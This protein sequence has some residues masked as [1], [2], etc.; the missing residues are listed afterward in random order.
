VSATDPSGPGR[1][2]ADEPPPRAT[3]TPSPAGGSFLSPLPAA[4]ARRFSPLP[5]A[6]A[7]APTVIGS[8]TQL[9]AA[10]EWPEPLSLAPQDLASDKL[11]R[12]APRVRA[13]PWTCPSLG[14]IP[15][16]AKIGQGGMGAVYYGLHLRLRREVAVKVLPFH[17]AEQ[18]PDLVKRFFREAQ[19]AARLTS[20]HLV[21]VLDV[22]EDHGLYFLVM[23]YVL[24]LSA[25]AYLKSLLAAGRAGLTEAEALSIA[26]AAA[27]GLAAAHR[28][29]I[30]H[31]DI[32]VDNILIPWA[33]RGR[34]LNLPAAKLADL[35]LGRMEEAGQTLTGTQATLGTP[36]Y[37]A[38]EQ[39]RDARHAGPPAD[40]FSLGAT[41]YAL[42][43]GRAPFTG[44]SAFEVLLAT[45]QKSHPP[46]AELRP[47]V[48]PAL[49]LLLDRCLAKDPAARFPDGVALFE[50]LCGLPRG[51]SPPPDLLPTLTPGPGVLPALAP[52][53]PVAASPRPAAVATTPAPVV[54]TSVA[55]AVGSSEGAAEAATTERTAVAP[56]YSSWAR[57]AVALVVLAGLGTG[58]WFYLQTQ[59]DRRLE[60]A[61]RHLEQERWDEAELTF[62]KAAAVPGFGS[63]LEAQEG[64]RRAERGAAFGR[65]LRE[66]AACAEAANWSAAELTYRRALEIP[67]YQED[68]RA[69][70]GLL[71]VT[72]AQ[73]F[74]LALSKGNALLQ[75]R[76]WSRAEDLFANALTLSG[77]E[78]DARA[79]TGQ[80]GARHG[81]A[82]TAAMEAAR[83]ALEKNAGPAAEEA[84]RQALAVPGY[85]QDG[86]AEELR[87]RITNGQ[88]CQEACE[89]AAKALDAGHFRSAATAYAQAADLAR[90]PH[91]AVSKGSLKA[92]LDGQNF[93]QLLADAEQA[94]GERRWPAASTALKSAQA[95]EGFGRHEQLL[96]L[97]E[98]VTNGQAFDAHLAA[99]EAASSAEH[100][101]E[102]EQS[103]QA[104]LQVP[105]FGEH[106]RARQALRYCRA[107]KAFDEALREAQGHL[108]AARWDQAAESFRKALAV[109][110]RDKDE[111]ARQGLA[112]A[113]AQQAAVAKKKAY[114]EALHEA[115]RLRAAAPSGQREAAA[116]AAVREAAQKA[117]DAGHPEVQAAQAL[118][119]EAEREEQA[120][121]RWIESD[122][123]VQQAL[124]AAGRQEWAAAEASLKQAL[125]LGARQDIA[126]LSDRIAQGVAR[127][128]GRSYW[129]GDLKCLDYHGQKWIVGVRGARLE[130]P[131]IGYA[132]LKPD[133][134]PSF[135]WVR[136]AET[137]FWFMKDEERGV[138]FFLN[139][140]RNAHVANAEKTERTE[141][142]GRLTAQADKWVAKVKLLRQFDKKL[143]GSGSIYSDSQQPQFSVEPDGRVRFKPPFWQP[144]MLDSVAREVPDET[145]K[146][147]I[148]AYLQF[149]V[150][151][152][153]GKAEKAEK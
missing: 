115:Q 126:E 144:V 33:E 58:T 111:R 12:D 83:G 125:A 100:W 19:M 71:K 69:H 61:R 142:C 145:A 151:E 51:A 95:V 25:G 54:A 153:G 122:R 14:G 128:A 81:R 41:L 27:A 8:G 63:S 129:E 123:C 94:A 120:A 113:E 65:L 26:G 18:Q 45:A 139:L 4:D 66:A 6:V 7:Y 90:Q 44:S 140:A 17:L 143:G 57:W 53:T 72:T 47:D 137:E 152:G 116:W 97:Q 42:L 29:G 86:A 1:A 135:F 149:M 109:E 131:L 43:T 99:G 105:G 23:E 76:D 98:T 13:G 102:A 77:Y 106:P 39:A 147:G 60:A 36:G 84:A 117:L 56:R 24:G 75:T 15:L 110:G 148:D 34:R 103:L 55:R 49:C 74:E 87:R 119:A 124:A 101:P 40:V 38:P 78:N 35:G 92:L 82:Y 112:Q 134:G 91:S 22:N 88:A 46:L 138:L 118:R 32:K 3:A 62:R 48:S 37:M 11:L 85:E 96:R 108:Q 21:S 20:P 114:E 93:A 141:W 30:V 73:A 10:L 2:G 59:F 16:L 80:E 136:V 28:A 52:S 104:A 79:K 68:G 31:R 132:R 146:R 133:T 150:P 107:G 5:A 50:A 130:Q 121:K 70:A 89:Q 64:I 127:S 67:G 9:A